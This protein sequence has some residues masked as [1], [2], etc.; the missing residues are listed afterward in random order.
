MY[1]FK[2]RRVYIGKN[3]PREH[4]KLVKFRIIFVKFVKMALKVCHP[5]PNWVRWHIPD[6]TGLVLV[7]GIG[8][9][10]LIGPHIGISIQ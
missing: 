6:Y 9:E 2:A 5:I 1:K 4:D 10:C 8:L 7:H 3:L